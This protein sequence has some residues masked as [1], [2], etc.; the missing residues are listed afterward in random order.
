MDATNRFETPTTFA[1]AR[2]E[3][4]AVLGASVIAL[5]THYREINWYVFAALFAVIDLVGYIPGAI[6]YKKHGEK[7]PKIYYVLYNSMHSLTPWIVGI[8]SW[9]VLVGPQWAF[10]AIPLHL[11]GDRAIFGNSMKTFQV[12]FEPTP[13]E[14]F[15]RFD[16]ALGQPAP[17]RAPLA[18]VDTSGL[19]AK[20]QS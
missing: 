13:H 6:A 20:G 19:R 9:C 10:L 16:L 4:A 5:L 15:K 1:L 3:Y 17:R 12:T 2:I 14:G 11:A 7:T 18:G 8:G